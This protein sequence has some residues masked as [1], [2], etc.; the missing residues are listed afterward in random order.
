MTRIM[1]AYLSGALIT[2]MILGCTSGPSEDKNTLAVVNAYQISASEFQRL[3][4]EDAKT[5]PE[6]RVTDQAKQDYLNEIIQKEVLIQEAKRLK[7]DQ[8]PKFIRTIERYWEATLIR[9]LMEAKSQEIETRVIVSQEDIQRQYARMKN[10]NPDLPPLT[11]IE[12]ELTTRI[13]EEKKTAMFQNWIEE[14]KQ[15]ANIQV[16]KK[17]MEDM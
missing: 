7:F 4:A 1:C 14:L 9:D 3:F 12:T 5:D 2:L 8:K 6:M 11:E 16:N 13:R 17:L 10:D 15:Q